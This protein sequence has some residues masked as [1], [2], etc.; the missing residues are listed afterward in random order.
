MTAQELYREVE[1]LEKKL[2]GAGIDTRLELQ[3]TVSQMV[4]RMR[5]QGVPIPSR[6]LRLDAALCEDAIEASFDNLPV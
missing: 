1:R 4:Q 2:D 5:V 3:P 6:L